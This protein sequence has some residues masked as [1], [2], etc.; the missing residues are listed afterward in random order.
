MTE[1]VTPSPEDLAS[2]RRA[3][4]KQRRRRNLQNIWRVFAISGL[5]ASSIWLI[6]NPFWLM[7]Q[8]SDQVVIEGNTMLADEAVRAVIAFEYPQPLLEIE[9]EEVANRLRT[10]SPIAFAQVERR[11]FPPRLEVMLQERQ[12]V[13]VTVPSR[14]DA[15]IA[16]ATDKT[17][18]NSPGLID[19]QGYWMPQET[20]M[21]F[22]NEFALPTLRVRGYH[23]RYQ[24]QWPELYQ[25]LQNS[26]VEVT[27]IDWR[28]PSNLILN[29]AVGR[30]HLGVYNPQHLPDQ[31]ATLPRFR[32]LTTESDVPS[33]DFIDLSNPQMPAVQLSQPPKSQEKAP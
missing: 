24:S 6:R 5:A 30:V 33:I 11:L 22:D 20:G 23:L 16:K 21:T 1:L 17:P 26:P 4:K 15:A 2:R 19:S 31:L 10:H 9:P 28:S 29:T 14:P 13:A 32:S 8:N 12:P 27:E 3:L 18:T 25:S 7:L